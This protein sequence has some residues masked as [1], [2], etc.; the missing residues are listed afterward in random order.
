MTGYRFATA[1]NPVLPMERARV[2]FDGIFSEPRLQHPE[3][4]AVGPDGWIWCGSENGQLLRVAPD[5]SRIEEMA[6]TGGFTLGLA[7]DGDDA[8]FACDLKHA[9]VFRFD[10]ATLELE[11]FS[12]PGIRIPN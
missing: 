7:F 2:L 1:E 3:G 6:S 12:P 11:R 10:L 5:G 9:A 8:L 4:V